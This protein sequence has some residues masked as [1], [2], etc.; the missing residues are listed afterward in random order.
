M[1]FQEGLCSMKLLRL[2]TKAPEACIVEMEVGCI[3]V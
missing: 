1:A 3:L 2:Y